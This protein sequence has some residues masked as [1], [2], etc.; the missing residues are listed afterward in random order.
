M[1]EVRAAEVADGGTSTAGTAFGVVTAFAICWAAGA[2][3]LGTGADAT[4][5]GSVLLLCVGAAGG[6]ESF[7]VPLDDGELGIGVKPVAARVTSGLGVA[8]AAPA[9]VG[10]GV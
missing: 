9:E 8:T 7:D 5:G 1:A 10:A 2:G 3:V 6:S 4:V